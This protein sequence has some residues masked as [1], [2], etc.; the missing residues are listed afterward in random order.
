MDHI[1][2][3][4][5]RLKLC[6][7]YVGHTICWPYYHPSETA[8]MINM[9]MMVLKFSMVSMVWKFYPRNSLSEFNRLN[10]TVLSDMCVICL[11][12]ELR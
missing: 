12:I 6:R 4:I 10:Q 9:F 5:Y 7:I 11:I 8:D 1:I 2:W 3:S